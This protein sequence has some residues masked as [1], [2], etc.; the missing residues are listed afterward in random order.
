VPWSYTVDGYR[1]GAWVMKQRSVF[2]KGLLEAD[3][4]RRLLEL[5]G[6]TWD[7]VADQWEEGFS[8]LHDYVD[9]YGNARVLGSYAV[10]GYKLGRWVIRQ[11]VN[12]AA[13]AL[14]A[15]CRRRLEEL[16]GWTWD[17]QADKWEEGF[18]RLLLYVERH[19]HARV[20]YSYTADDYKLGQWV[21]NQRMRR[22]TLEADRQHRLEDLT[23]WNWDPRADRWE[24]GF[25]RLL[26]Y[27][28]RNGHARVPQSHTID[29]Y[30]LG[31]WANTQ[32]YDFA[33][34]TLEAERQLRLEDLPGWTWEPRADQWEQGFTRLL[35]YVE[36]NGH[37]RVPRS[38]TVDGY[39]LGA[40]VIKQRANHTK[41]TL[42]A[43]RAHRLEKLPGWA[44]DRQ[45]DQ[46][47]E[48]FTRLLEYVERNNHARIPRSYTVDGYK[49]GVWVDRQ[50]M[51]RAT[52]EA[53][54]QHRLEDLTGWTW[55]PRADQWAEGFSWLLD[56]VDRNG[57]ARVPQS[58]TVDGYALGAWVST[59]R[60]NF[61]K[62]SLDAD[63]QRRLQALP[64]WTWKVRSSS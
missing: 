43:D 3:R 6:W 49:L 52:L 56:Y 32:R 29:G 20:P 50:R 44:W 5:T 33:K 2:D 7:P 26:E 61:A 11:R 48:G 37:A 45:A 35:E 39:R 57:H 25:T 27:V 23:G 9:C 64:G 24:Q 10:D 16:P 21:S 18:Q 47:E 42:D 58:Y 22:A 31:A 1:L 8:R 53:D 28:E 14:D 12:Y 38:H 4:E 34:G 54:R 62:G 30:A 55:D 19:G 60:G 15:D 13:G 36:R 41:G 40:W 46:W 59:Q 63:R 17:R 51:R